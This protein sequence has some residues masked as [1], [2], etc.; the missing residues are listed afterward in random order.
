[1]H[2][3]VCVF[4]RLC[5]CVSIEHCTR[6]KSSVCIE[7]KVLFVFHSLFVFHFFFCILAKTE[8]ELKAS[9]R[10]LNDDTSTTYT[11]HSAIKWSVSERRKKMNSQWISQHSTTWVCTH[12][13][14]IG[15]TKECI[16]MHK[17]HMCVDSFN[18][19][20]SDRWLGALLCAFLSLSPFLSLCAVL[21]CMLV[22]ISL[23]ESRSSATVHS[24]RS[25]ITPCT[26]TEK[27]VFAD[28]LARSSSRSSSL[29]VRL[30]AW[31]VGYFSYLSMSWWHFWLEFFPIPR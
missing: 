9:L 30:C 7:W 19:Q 4:V 10:K 8:W 12:T 17:T 1:M 6:E 27:Y 15:N 11:I 29:S 20:F 2:V 31:C 23:K 13:R 21:I 3:Y 18:Q 26:N 22:T 14:G 16:I 5:I 24:V 25:S 28:Q